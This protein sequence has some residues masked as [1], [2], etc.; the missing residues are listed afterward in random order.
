MNRRNIQTRYGL[1]VYPNP[2]G[3]IVIKQES[4]MS[5]EDEIVIIDTADVPKIV[6]W[7][8]ELVPEAESIG[9]AYAAGEDT[10]LDGDEPPNR[11]EPAP[12][13]TGPKRVQ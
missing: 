12:S 6:R 10:E 1:S 3:Q 2:Y 4:P 7:L 5:D 13:Y 9:E 8:Q 11:S